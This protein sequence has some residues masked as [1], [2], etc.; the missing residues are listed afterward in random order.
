MVPT[1]LVRT[2]SWQDFLLPHQL[3]TKQNKTGVE[4]SDSSVTCNTQCSNPETKI[5]LYVNYLELKTNK[6]KQLIDKPPYD[7][8]LSQTV[9]ILEVAI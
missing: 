6:K 3:K 1:W 5:A 2:L 8:D 4:F 7:R 9:F